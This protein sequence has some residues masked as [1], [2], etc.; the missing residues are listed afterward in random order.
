MSYGDFHLT[1][2]ELPEDLRP[3]ERLLRDGV[4]ALA[5]HELVALIL[6]TG[7]R[8]ETAMDLAT[9]ILVERGG[10]RGL[11]DSTVEELSSIKG[12]GLAKAATLKGALE[13][14][15]R[16]NL[17][18]N[19]GQA[20][21]TSPSDVSN[22]LM[23]EM[24]FLDREHFRTVLLNTKNRIIDIEAVSVG[25][26]SS[27]IVHPREVFKGPIKKSAA[28]L[29]LVHNHP[30]GDPTPSS[31]D[32]GVTKRLIESGKLLGIEILDHVIIGDN[33]YC[34]LKEKGLI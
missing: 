29:I 11:M 22:L 5:N 15:R 17:S 9:R 19:D 20:S 10:L 25:S 27:S 16:V 13:L 1:V 14:G 4:K 12:V 34:S 8:S 7:T 2:K 32:V 30:S 23:E 21:V 28:A 18:S 6:R 33:K 24:K 31:E 3:R 26:L